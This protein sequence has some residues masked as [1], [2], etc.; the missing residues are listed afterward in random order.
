MSLDKIDYEEPR[1][2]LDK[3]MYLEKPVVEPIPIAR[4]ISKLD[5]YFDK[6]DLNGAERLLDYWNAEAKALHD[7]RGE[8][9]IKNEMLG[10]YRKLGKKEEALDTAKRVLELC[11]EL[12]N[13]ESPDGATAFIN[14]GTVYKAFG[15][16][17]EALPIFEKAKSIYEKYLAKNDERLAGLYNN[18]ALAETD[19]GNFHEAEKLFL[20]ALDVLAGVNNSEPEQ[21]VTYLNIASCEE[22]AKGREEAMD[23]ITKCI[24]RAWKLLD[25][26]GLPKDGN[27]AFVC[28]K[29][30]PGFEYFGYQFYAGTLKMRS[31]EIY[32]KANE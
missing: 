10:I 7:L 5:E 6:N 13:A 26:P 15:M 8:F 17:D 18:M 20:K 11:D 27:Y 3:N 21:A 9:S 4:V 16:A 14:I 30:A 29:C 22:A 2:I 28:D 23:T 12:G 1:C 32:A 31:E 25:K 24:D 19:L